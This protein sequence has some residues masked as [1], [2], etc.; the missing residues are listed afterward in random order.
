MK[1]IP[2]FEEYQKLAKERARSLMDFR[3]PKE[4]NR[5]LETPD[6]LDVMKG[7]YEGWIEQVKAGETTLKSF[8]DAA[9][10]SAYCLD[11]MF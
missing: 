6:A 3:D 4:V 2:T 9:N 1:R 5:F 10:S 11:L 7:N 8:D